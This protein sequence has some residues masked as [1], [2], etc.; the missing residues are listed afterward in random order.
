MGGYS[1]FLDLCLIIIAV[2]N[3]IQHFP[4]KAWEIN[5]NCLHSWKNKITQNAK[6]SEMIPSVSKNLLW[7]LPAEIQ[8][9]K[10]PSPSIHRQA[11]IETDRVSKEFIEFIRTYQKPGQDIYKQ[12]KLFLDTMSHKRVS[13]ELFLSQQ[14]GGRGGKC[15]SSSSSLGFLECG[16]S[17]QMVGLI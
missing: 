1:L 2:L 16:R 12:C 5:D 8:E 4:G 9:A 14:N 10:A 17:L 11:S 13:S 15:C 6:I 7:I 3:N